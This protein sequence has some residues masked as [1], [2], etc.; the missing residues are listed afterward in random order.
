MTS[1][2]ENPL[3]V[4]AGLLE[5]RRRYEGWITQ[6]D[7]R[8]GHAPEHVVQRVR[9]DY[10]SRLEGV[11]GQ[12]RGR[13]SDLQASA[14]ALRARIE[15]LTAEEGLRRDERAETEL[16]AAVG[17]F[18]SDAARAAMASCDEAIAHL[19]RERE[20]QAGEY[21]KLEEILAQVGEPVPTTVSSAPPPPAR[22]EAVAPAAPH[23]PTPPSALEELAFLQSVVETRPAVPTTPASHAPANEVPPAAAAGRESDLLP[24]PLLTNPRRSVT[25]LSSP[26]PQVRDPL[27]GAQRTAPTLTPGSIPSFFKDMPTEQV[28]TLKCQECGT[29]NYPTEWYC[30]RCG[31]ELAAM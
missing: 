3:E 22:V 18:P 17:E 19:S 1:S 26:T 7:D 14:A 10:V 11:M 9:A 30:E 15:A 12:L 28:K 25:P 13:A 6:L 24:P 4:L 31:G 21:R 2:P 5:E 23:T 27:A 8:R 16:R 29:M 20:A